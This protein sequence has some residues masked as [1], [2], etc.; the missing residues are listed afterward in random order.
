MMISASTKFRTIG[1]ASVLA[2]STALTGAAF[3][4]TAP[5]PG[6]SAPT[7]TAPTPPAN[8]EECVVTAGTL[9][10]APGTDADGF[11]DVSGDPLGLDVQSG[12]VVQGP[13]VITGTTTGDVDGSIQTSNDGEGGLLVGD[14]SAV[15]VNGFIQTDGQFAIGVETG[16][17]AVLTNDGT[18][19]TTGDNFSDGV[20]L[21]AGSTFTNNDLVQTDGAESFGVFGSGD[22]L[23]VVNADTG[24]II[25]SGTGSFGIAV[26]NDSE[27]QNDGLIQTFGDFAVGIDTQERATVTNTG[28]IATGG[29]SSVGVGIRSDSSFTNTATGVVSTTG[30]E[31]IG[32]RAINNSVIVNDG[33]IQTGGAS[34]A[35]IRTFAGADITNNGTLATT[36]DLSDAIDVR[37]DAVITNAGTIQTDGSESAGV[38]GLG[39]NLNLTNTADGEIITTG[40]GS[41][42]VIALD[43]AVISNAGL[44]QTTNDFAIGIDTQEAGN[45][46]NS[47]T[48]DTAGN[49]STAVGIR[50]DATFTNTASGVITTVGDEAEGVASIDNSV[51]VN[52]GMIETGG[53]TAVGVRGF[54]GTTVT[55]NGTILTTGGTFADAVLVRANAVITNNGLI[56]TD[57]DEAAGVS[58]L[59]DNLQLTNAAG[60]QIVTNGLGSY[61]ILALDN[62]IITNDGLIQTNEF[63]GIGIDTQEAGTVTNNG[64]IETAGDFGVGVGIRSD[65]TFTNSAAGIVSTE[66]EEA[67]A[68]AMIQNSVVINDG[69]IETTGRNAN[70]IRGFADNTV[71]NNGSIVT[72]G[73]AFADAV[74]VSDNSLVTNNGQIQ[75]QGSNSRG[76]FGNGN[77][78]TVINTATGDIST[79]GDGGFAIAVSLDNDSALTNDGVISTLGANA[80]AVEAR[81]GATIINNGS[82]TTAGAAGTGITF[83]ADGALSNDG[84]LSTAGDDAF[85]ISTGDNAV[86]NLSVNSS[87]TTL[88]EG[89]DAIAVV[90]TGDIT[91]AGLVSATG[92]AATAVAISGDATVTNS[93]DILSEAERALDIGG[94]ANV[95][96]TA[97]GTIVSNSDDGIRL[98]FDGSVILNEGAITSGGGG[99]VNAFGVNDVAITNAGTITTAAGA[100]QGIEAG[101]GLTLSNSG[102]VQASSSDAV[103]LSGGSITNS[104]TLES[105]GSG[106]MAA[107]DAAINFD[108]GSDDGVV[109]NLADGVVRGD[110]GI[111]SDAG[112]SGAQQISNFGTIEGRMGDAVL[113]GDG[114]DEF[115]QNVG[116]SVIG[117]INLQG[118]DDTFVLLGMAS[119]VTGIIDGGMGTDVAT[120]SGTLD[121]DNITGFE[122]LILGDVTVAGNRTLDG[123]VVVGGNVTLGL[124]VDSLTTSGSI[125]LEETGTITIQTPLDL[126]LVGQT[127]L[128]L[129]DGTGF[130][131]NGATINIIDDDLLVD[132]VP[133]EG[134]LFVEVVAVN[135]FDGF[136]DPNAAAFGEAVSAAVA[137]GT[138]SQANFNFLT[139]QPDDAALEALALDALPNLSAGAAREIFETSSAASEV[140]NRHL[141]GDGTG[142]WGQFTV[143][144]ATQDSLA[145]S[146]GGY[147]SDQLI[148]TVGG[149][150]AAGDFGRIGLLA[151]YADIENDDRS[152]NGLRGETEVEALKLGVY[153]AV[154]FASRGFINGEFSYLTGEISSDRN[155]ALGAIGSTYDYDGWAYS[156]TLGYDILPDEGVSL[157]PSIGINGAT[158]DY[159]DAIEAGGFGFT[160]AREHADFAEL[161]A[162]VELGA[163]VS[164][165]VDGF[166]RGTVIHDINED[167]SDFTLTSAELGTFVVTTPARDQDRFELAAGANIDVSETFSLE[168]GYLGDFGGDYDGHSARITGRLKF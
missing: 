7:P 36:G 128:V 40:I 97:D 87:V 107:L 13:I 96:N 93:G 110:I 160:V 101:S 140:L 53:E 31:A 52:D 141:E 130:T 22:D 82:I 15:N 3:A 5:A 102:L 131:N 37:E 168:V 66:G 39:D 49:F 63:F 91:N 125:T 83:L 88:G 45:V 100:D 80:I 126:E 30:D 78:I 9:V 19:Y 41:F 151:S 50:S 4:Q 69:S 48:I 103:S 46:T 143:R 44:V 54:A 120:L 58:A 108:A 24:S 132:Y 138:I 79:E 89:A 68:V 163:Q 81:D 94:L 76:V 12:S 98:A 149:D 1:G 95:T 6:M 114:N 33:T 8:A 86:I 90:G 115:Q 47:G 84:T 161:R 72:M 17:N 166:I 75:A 112:N 21:G 165:G 164:P 65:A 20:S 144:G 123:D 70:G 148:F 159:D 32:L 119:S 10:C 105:L 27:V 135:Q 25:T 118:G 142:V 29:A 155:G 139:T 158:F 150:V 92:V 162:A 28:N 109:M 14:A 153:G 134:S 62:A 113:L 145:Q 154:N 57:G 117:N 59:G 116:A 23:T 152:A 111:N 137:A 51:I 156:A 71:T 74:Q 85:G 133:I 147:S 42:G 127:V 146:A 16:A 129:Q 26:L 34:A 18:I 35:G 64:T 167:I 11:F 61:G 124:G 2:L 56:Q 99:A 77:T 43:N 106:S 73:D 60:A 157:T 121:A 104:G 38:L 67:D 55:N 122:T 136:I